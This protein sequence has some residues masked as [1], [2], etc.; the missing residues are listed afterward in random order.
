MTVELPP[1]PDDP[2]A[3]EL[4]SFVDEH[5][6]AQ[7]YRELDRAP[8]FPRSEFLAMGRAG[9]LGLDRAR[10]DGGRGISLP[11]AGRLVYRLAF[12]SGTT[13]AKL[14]LQPG[15]SSVLGDH[16][17]RD[18][19]TQYYRPLVRGEILIGT[20]LTEPEA[21]SDLRALST[22]AEPTSDGYLLTGS[23]SEIAFAQDA[24]WAIVY[25]RVPT[26]RSRDGLTALLVRQDQPGVRREV[27]P[28]LGEHWMRRG[29]VHYERVA[30]SSAFRIGEEGAAL[31]YLLPEL[32]RER[33]LLAM[34]YLG[35]ARASWDEAVRRVGA[36]R[37]FDRALAD[38]EAVGFALVEDWA[39]LE[40][41]R[42]YAERTLERLA[43][44]EAVD[45][46][47]ALSKV[48][49]TRVALRTIDHALQFSG[50]AGY[51]AELAHEQRWRDVRS[52]PIAH[53][54]TELL[55][56]T[57]ARRIWRRPARDSDRTGPA[58]SSR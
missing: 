25:A 9:W 28:D 34:I 33:A 21:G 55:L 7:R 6:L 47:A 22:V 27:V 39:E 14:S 44:G 10:E 54:S 46:D 16:G 52:G 43:Q 45:Q 41:T 49:A 20:Q 11:R 13:F 37:V 8:E 42:L 29:R 40:A 56:R 58:D 26:E 1:L 32:D 35:V 18:L 19:V 50:G 4:D 57:A 36:R 30:V 31:R 2:L 51:S 3:A 15:F 38:H 23:K 48:L 53:G 17:S 5:R 12:R 24:S